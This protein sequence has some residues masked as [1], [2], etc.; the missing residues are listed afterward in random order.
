[1]NLTRPTKKETAF[2][3]SAILVMILAGVWWHHVP[4]LERINRSSYYYGL[5]QLATQAMEKEDY[6]KA[7]GLLELAI[8]KSP[9]TPFAY[10]MIGDLFVREGRISSAR[11]NYQ[12]AITRLGRGFTNLLSAQQQIS[13]RPRI[14]DKLR[15]LV[16]EPAG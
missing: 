2:A 9:D 1:M 15:K 12:L 11:T 16:R 7:E 13:E 4:L 3:F 8:K 5:L 10:E 6:R 14:E